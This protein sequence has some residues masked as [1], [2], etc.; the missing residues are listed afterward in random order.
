MPYCTQADLELRISKS[1]LA[2]LT[3]DSANATAADSSVV[4]ALIARADNFID[5]YISQV[6]AVP[7]STVPVAVK[8]ISIDLSC[9][10]A[11]QRRPANFAMPK[12]WE[13]V[14]LN[15]RKFLQQIADEN[16]RMDGTTAVVSKEAD[17]VA[18]TQTVNFE[19][20]ESALSRF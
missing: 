8:N 5:A 13:Y 3:N 10:Y 11:M 2:Q 17:V 7:L 12:A 9:F 14:E 15:A 16:I 20:P 19:D 4:S 1:V 6:Y 18:P